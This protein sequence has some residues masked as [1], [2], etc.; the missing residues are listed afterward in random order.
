MPKREEAAVRLAAHYEQVL[1]KYGDDF[2]C[3]GD[4]ARS[5]SNRMGQDFANILRGQAE[6]RRYAQ[7]N[8]LAAQICSRYADAAPGLVE[9]F[10]AGGSGRSI[11]RAW[12]EDAV[13][14]ANLCGNRRVLSA[15]FDRLSSVMLD[16]GESELAQR[17]SDS[18]IEA[19]DIAQDCRAVTI[20]VGNRAAIHVANGEFQH[21]EELYRKCLE[22]FIAE[23]SRREEGITIGNLALVEKA[24]GSRD[25]SVALLREA[26][27]IAKEQG[28]IESE[29]HWSLALGKILVGEDPNGSSECYAESLEFARIIDDSVAVVE[30]ML[31]LAESNIASG[32]LA[33]SIGCLEQALDLLKVSPRNSREARAR[34]L[35]AVAFYKS[36]KCKAAR[37]EAHLALRLYQAVGSETVGVVQEFLRLLDAD[38]AESAYGNADGPSTEV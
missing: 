30:A 22:F 2:D 29:L 7:R 10:S 3:G 32:N 18:A 19:G 8:P 13:L 17:L 35:L 25:R 28:D 5:S 24:R 15:H 16:L 1:R 21:A 23:G 36:G 33:Q 11:W 26:L 37:I 12:I 4:A 27:G 38:G 31:G 6:A 9:R 14:A 34:W 20:A